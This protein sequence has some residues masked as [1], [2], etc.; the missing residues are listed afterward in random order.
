MLLDLLY[1]TCLQKT[2][3]T[4]ISQFFIAVCTSVFKEK[5]QPSATRLSHQQ[6]RATP[7]WAVN[8]YILFNSARSLSVN[9][10]YFSGSLCHISPQPQLLWQEPT[11]ASGV[12]TCKFR[13][14][15]SP[16]LK[17]FVDRLTQLAIF[18]MRLQTPLTLGHYMACSTL[19]FYM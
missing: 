16:I 7:L 10:T 1:H 17:E 9:P 15:Y 13:S 4:F 6:P 3:F 8:Y 12:H 2:I 19:M 18:F 11:S 5:A 14:W